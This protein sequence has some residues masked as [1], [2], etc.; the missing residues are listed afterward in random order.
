MWTAVS[1]E[2]IRCTEC[3]HT[4][5]AGTD[6]LSQ[7]PVPMPDGFRRRKYDNFCLKCDECNENRRKSPCYVRYLGHWYAHKEKTAGPANCVNCGDAIP[8]GAKTV[9]Q[10]LYVWPTPDTE[11]DSEIDTARHTSAAGGV[12]V[13]TATK[14]MD[15]AGWHNL[16]RATQTPVHAWR[17]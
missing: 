10:K 1:E 5:P 6:C 9:A 17:T 13:G 14:P 2:D 12:A 15:A 16:S 4:I 8:V 7:M 3:Y 11:P